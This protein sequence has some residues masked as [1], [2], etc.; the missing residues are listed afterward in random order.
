MA[1]RARHEGITF[2]RVAAS[3]FFVKLSP[4]LFFAHDLINLFSALIICQSL[5]VGCINPSLILQLKLPLRTVKLKSLA[6]LDG[7]LNL[8]VHG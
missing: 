6:L 1:I 7:F 8:R 5:G 2:R 3:W 4:R